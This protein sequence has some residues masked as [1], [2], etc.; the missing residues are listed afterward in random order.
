MADWKNRMNQIT[1]KVKSQLFAKGVDNMNQLQDIFLVSFYFLNG[2]AGQAH[3]AH[4]SLPSRSKSLRL[5]AD[6]GLKR[7]GLSGATTLGVGVSAGL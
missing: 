3:A 4:L 1:N 6:F 5:M 7:K 2:A